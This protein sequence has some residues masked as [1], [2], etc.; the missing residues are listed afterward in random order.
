LRKGTKTP[1]LP[2][3][4]VTKEE[5]P[6]TNTPEKVEKKEDA[7]T[8]EDDCDFELDEILGDLEKDNAD[9]PKRSEAKVD[10]GDRDLDGLEDFPSNAEALASSTPEKKTGFVEW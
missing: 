5:Q 9:P 3:K 10:A 1:E 6:E 4:K 7:K 2:T 8:Q